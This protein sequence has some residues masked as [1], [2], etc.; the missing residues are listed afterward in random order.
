MDPFNSQYILKE[1]RWL[2]IDYDKGISII[3]VGFG[4]CYM[5]LNG[6]GLALSH[7]P[8]INYINTFLYGFRM[9]LFFIVSGLLVGKSLNK[10]GYN[11]Y[12]SDRINNILYPLFIWGTIQITIQLLFSRYTNNGTTPLNYLYLLTDPR[13]NGHFWY[14][15][16]LFFIGGIYALL[17]SKLKLGPVA[18]II[19]GFALY[20]VSAWIKLTGH[21]WGLLNDICEYYFF[22][23]LGDLV[24]K[25]MLAEGNIERFS[26]WK[27]FLPLIVAF[28]FVQYYF[29]RDNL[30]VTP[31]G[32]QY[33]EY[34]HPFLFLFEALLGCITSVS[35]SFLL[36]KYRL[37]TFFRIVGYH[38]LFIYCMQIIVMSLARIVCMNLLHLYYVPALVLIVWTSG[39]VLPIFFYNFCLKYNLWWLY[40][41]KK[42]VKQVEYMKASNIFWFDRNNKKLL[43][44]KEE[45][46]L[47]NTN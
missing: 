21:N 33:T 13:Q 16:A 35:F 27:I 4:H 37:F 29:T 6:H 26:S 9:P 42:P 32:V 28:G 45:E 19:I 46:A 23:A 7:Y 38:S 44:K 1:K 12:L 20:S 17:K 15:N 22:F 47:L 36:Q 3:L 24:S 31:V 34:H 2:W 8:F 18:Q 5:T 30:Q 41:Y 11:G 25:I 14:L 10:K 39:I 40:T 43:E